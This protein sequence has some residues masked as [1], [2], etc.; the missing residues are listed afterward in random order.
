MLLP[1]TLEGERV[2]LE[3]LGTQH[4]DAQTGCWT[5]GCTR[6]TTSTATCRC[7][8]AFSSWLSSRAG[9]PE[10]DPEIRSALRGHVPVLRWCDEA[11]PVLRRF[12]AALP[13]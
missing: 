4:V 1:L 8:G 2:R 5:G 6:R 11:A 10:V 13:E 7:C 3:P 9:S 12:A